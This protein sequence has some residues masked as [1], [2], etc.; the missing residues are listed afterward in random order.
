VKTRMTASSAYF[1]SANPRS[2]LYGT[3]TPRT[4]IR[5][6]PRRSHSEIAPTGQT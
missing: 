3:F 2:S 5:P 4:P 6:A 1:R